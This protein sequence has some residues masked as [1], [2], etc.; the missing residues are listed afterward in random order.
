MYNAI[1]LKTNTYVK[2]PCIEKLYTKNMI[3]KS[4][5]K[6]IKKEQV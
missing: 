1:V 4:I 6:Y 3:Q 2:V 5:F